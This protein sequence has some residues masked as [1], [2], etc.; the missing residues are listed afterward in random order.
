M[1]FVLGTP[2]DVTKCGW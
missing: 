1:I 2:P